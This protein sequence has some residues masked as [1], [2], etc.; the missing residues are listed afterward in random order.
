MDRKKPW[1]TTAIILDTRT[2]KKD[3]TYPV[4]LRITYQREQKYY[5]IKGESY[6]EDKFEAIMNSD[7]RGN[8]K[9]KR[10]KFTSIESRAIEIIDNELQEFSFQAFEGLYMNKRKRSLALQ[11]IFENKI[12]E[13]K[14]EGKF[15]S[16]VLYNATL[17]S[18]TDF[19]EGF[20]FSKI[21]P[22]YLQQY[23]KWMVGVETDIKRKKS[24]TTVG[25]YMRY[26]KSIINDAIRL[27]VFSAFD[28]PFGNSK[29]GKYQIPSSRPHKRA[30]SLLEI[31]KLF[32]YN[33]Q[34]MNEK[35][36][37]SYFLFSYLCNGMNM[38]DIANL[39]FKNIVGNTMVFFR[40][41]TLNLTKEKTEILVHLLPETLKIINDIGNES[42]SEDDYVFPIY[43][44]EMLLEERFKKLKQQI[45]TTN[46]Y[47]RRIAQ[48]LELEPKIT[49]YW[50][51]HSYATILK[52]SGA[53]YEFIGENLGH[54]STKVTKNYLDSFEDE[55]RKQFAEKLIDFKE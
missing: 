39:K 46:K 15:Q 2:K 55:Q 20:S 14:E 10:L 27:G 13:L 45:K 9:D 49:T 29:D 4:K 33:P 31:K 17:K 48:K 28:Y 26:L 54:S 38:A 32:E 47:L 11:D 7:S 53:S 30:L 25:I 43:T 36:A 24:Y 44:H 51:R 37:L 3:K 5:T 34:D 40:Q 12:T 8:N 6:T 50:A 42:A 19:D 41:K 1:V 18:F 22:K 52:R 23:E 35:L 16:A 21:S